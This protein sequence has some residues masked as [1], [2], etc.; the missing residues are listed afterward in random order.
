MTKLNQHLKDVDETYLEHLMHASGFGISMIAGGVACLLHAIFPFAFITTG[1]D[2]I[3]K[4]HD[5]MVVNRL[6][7]SAT[8]KARESAAVQS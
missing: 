3:T 4:L 1:S 8:A 2:A 7:P 6:K 5:R